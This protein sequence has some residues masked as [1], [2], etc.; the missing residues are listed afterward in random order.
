MNTKIVD[1]LQKLVEL[2]KSAREIGSL[3][4]ANAVAEKIQA[5]LTQYSLTM[6]DIE[7]KEERESGEQVDRQFIRPSD[8]GVKY[9][10]HIIEWQWN[11]LQG[12]AKANNCH[13]FGH[14]GSNALTVIGFEADRQVVISLYKY[15]V[16]LAMQLADTA[17]KT[18]KRSDEYREN[19]FYSSGDKAGH[20]R[21]W[22]NSYLIG[23]ASAIANRMAE[24]RRQAVEEAEQ[25][26]EQAGALVHLRDKDALVKGYVNQSKAKPHRGSQA[27]YNGDGYRQ[28]RQAG[29]SVALGQGALNG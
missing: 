12:I 10:S 14:G 4:E 23:F 7:I 25:H 28:G 9:T 5:F 29:E 19:Y 8:V 24:T 27:G 17:L 22:K 13:T 15:F 1:K 2:E 16:H 18:Y 20:S 3:S 21:V 6:S 11:L 26:A